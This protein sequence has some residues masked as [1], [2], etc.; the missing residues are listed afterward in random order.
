MGRDEERWG[1]DLEMERDLG[2]IWRE[3]ERDMEK[4]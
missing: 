1:R 2:E 3:M 4:D